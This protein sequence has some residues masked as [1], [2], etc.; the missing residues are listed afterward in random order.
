[1]TELAIVI[2]SLIILGLGWTLFGN[3][4][5][6]PNSPH[7]DTGYVLVLRS[8]PA[9]FHLVL[10]YQAWDGVE[11]D[12]KIRSNAIVYETLA[13][14]EAKAR[15]TSLEIRSKVVAEKATEAV[16]RIRKARD[17][18]EKYRAASEQFDLDYQEFRKK[19]DIWLNDKSAI[20]PPVRPVRPE[21]TF[22]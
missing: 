12:A 7:F 19:W 20:E 11:D 22:S 18:E 14:A 3:N 17:E 13:E 1:M 2:A 9:D 6:P 16:A 10:T 5:K 4:S 21:R 15:E 8:G